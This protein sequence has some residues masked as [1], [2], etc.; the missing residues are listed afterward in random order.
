MFERRSPEQNGQI[1]ESSFQGW[2]RYKTVSLVEEDHKGYVRDEDHVGTLHL[3]FLQMSEER[4]DLNSLA[5]PCEPI[6][7]S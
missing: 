4:N 3:S 2:M 1:R 6:S 5:Q 7:S